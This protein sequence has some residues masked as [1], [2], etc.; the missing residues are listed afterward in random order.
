[1]GTP[2]ISDLENLTNQQIVEIDLSDF[3]ISIDLVNQGFK[4]GFIK[5][6]QA[7]ASYVNFA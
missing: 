2:R 4:C 1:M 5:N 7:P 3:E 6:F